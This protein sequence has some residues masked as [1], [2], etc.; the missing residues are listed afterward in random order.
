MRLVNIASGISDSNRRFIGGRV[1][2]CYDGHYG[3]VCDRSWDMA[4]A[5]VACKTYRDQSTTA[6]TTLLCE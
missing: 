2:V 3:S 1:E 6:N 5:T 4:D